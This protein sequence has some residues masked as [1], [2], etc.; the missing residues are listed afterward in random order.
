LTA[1]ELG[2]VSNLSSLYALF[3]VAGD[4]LRPVDISPS[5]LSYWDDDLITIQRYAGKTN[6]QFTR[7][8]L[9]L[10]MAA[11]PDGFGR[12]LRVLDPVCGRGT[13]LN[14]AVRYGFD[15]VGIE[16]DGRDIDAYWSFFTT[17]L[18]NGRVRHE[19]EGSGR[20]HRVR[21]ALTKEEL[22]AGRGQEVL[23][24][25]ANTV[26]VLDHVPKRS[27]DLVVADLPYGVQHG[28]HTGLGLQRRPAELLADAL[29]GWFAALRPGGAIGLSFNVHTLSTAEARQALTDAGFAPV[30]LATGTGDISFEHRVDQAV[31]RDL[32]IARR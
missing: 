28:S 5:P 3:E 1:A 30:D 32:V 12:R 14:Q 16:L 31:V 15:A 19:T 2:V 6:E 8:L 20:R 26:H 22:R 4:S 9:N 11:V 18:K 27:V 23:A 25:A 7:L 17:W 21:F 24:V 10:T 13:T 29:P